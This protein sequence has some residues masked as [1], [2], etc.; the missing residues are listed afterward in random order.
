MQEVENKIRVVHLVTALESGGAEK[1]LFDTI[2]HTRYEYDHQVVVLSKKGAY[3]EK[4]L[5]IGV[6]VETITFKLLFSLLLSKKKCIVHS[7][8]YHSHMASLLF[9]LVGCPVIWSI[10]SSILTST[11]INYKLKI[12]ALLSYAVPR[13][14]IFVSRLSQQ[15]HVQC[16]FTK[17]KSVV[18]YN[19]VDS[20]L[21]NNKACGLHMDRRN[22]SI[23]MIARFHPI[24]DHERF[25]SI[26]AIALRMNPSC[27]FY[28]IGKDNDNSNREL[29]SLIRK[30]NLVERV[31]LLGEVDKIPEL[32]PC[33]DLLVS[34]SK[35]ESFGLTIVEA[36][37]SNTNI[38]TVNL[39]IM[40]ELFGSYSPNTG[41]LA[42]E[43]IAQI[44]LER[45]KVKPEAALTRYAK[46]YSINE[47]I[48]SY[49][50]IY[51]GYSK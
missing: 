22:V 33:F 47:M 10:H 24:K 26:A 17:K 5:N 4:I 23:A 16:G 50:S 28:L 1:V 20:R 31:K 51:K 41:E 29:L 44:W 30:Y 40:D 2:C 3:L 6:T 34:T 8:L 27:C 19:G 25:L 15:Q 45:S 49:Q 18:I 14:I 21:F 32:L 38:S 46:K 9:K 39:A 13:K 11:F 43:D 42:D 36:I 12:T 7:Y 37:L 35:S 48:K